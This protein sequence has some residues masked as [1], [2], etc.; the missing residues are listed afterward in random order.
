MIKKLRLSAYEG[1]L[2]VGG[3]SGW[4]FTVLYVCRLSLANFNKDLATLLDSINLTFLSA[5][6]VTLAALAVLLVFYDFEGILSHKWLRWLPGVF[7]AESGI[8]LSLTEAKTMTVYAAVA[9]IAA[10]V[11]G[12]AMLTCI[13][14]VKVG[15]RIFS[16]CAGLA[17]GGVIRALSGVIIEFLPD[18]TGRILVSVLIGV[19]AVLLVHT[20]SFSKEAMPL[21]SYAEAKPLALLK[22]VPGV[23]ALIFILGGAFLFAH[24]AIEA[25]GQIMLPASFA[26]YDIL[27]YAAFAIAA[28]V[29]VFIVKPHALASLFAFSAALSAASCVLLSLPNFNS[30]E[31]VFFSI[32]NFTA[33]AG[34]KACMY[35]VVVT[36]SLDRPHPLFYA[37]FGYGTLICSELLGAILEVQFPNADTHTYLWTLLLL[38]PVGGLFIS[39][40]MQRSGFSQE[41]LER[42]SKIKRIISSVCYENE[43]SERERK[44]LILLVLE[45]YSVDMMPDK[46]GLSRNTVKAQLRQLME[47]LG[48]D[49][50]D[51]LTELINE[52]IRKEDEKSEKKREEQ[53]AL[54]AEVIRVPI[55]GSISADELTKEI[56][57]PAST[58]QSSDSD[59]EEEDGEV[60]SSEDE[61]V[62]EENG[63]EDTSDSSDS[64]DNSDTPDTS[65]TPADSGEEE[66]GEP[67]DEPA[68]ETEGEPADEPA[69][70]PT[71]EAE[72]V[73]STDTVSEEDGGKGK[74]N[75]IFS[76]TV[77]RR[78][79]KK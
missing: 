52:R 61:E 5:S 13:L 46:L 33:L 29:L 15:Q 11:G 41:Q 7:M 59:D 45:E 40:S 54:N 22:K 20:T 48:A 34:F 26:N 64:S 32:L 79:K 76:L 25:D 39:M 50:V 30:T 24:N 14:K 12:L 3:F 21:L 31:A 47:K 36:F 27:T 56:E 51:A 6:V 16:V 72:G 62:G 70:E 19:V 71:D 1:A 37:V 63:G 58:E 55:L 38:I 74:G 69:N 4:Y 68:E 57:L 44:M 8:A 73:S 75:K 42:R 67:T 2:R 28:G 53:S 17:M 43:L 35:L 18:R 65:D 60:E 23:Y 66:E 49:D 78:K 9:G 10:A 77:K